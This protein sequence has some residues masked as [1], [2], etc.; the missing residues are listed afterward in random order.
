[1]PVHVQHQIVQRQSI[2]FVAVEHLPNGVN[3]RTLIITRLRRYVIRLSLNYLKFSKKSL[4]VRK[5]ACSYLVDYLG[6]AI[7]IK[8]RVP[9]SKCTLWREIYS[10]SNQRKIMETFPITMATSAEII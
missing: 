4:R 6:L 8:A 7:G 1:M 5:C 9:N 2:G 3:P 10:A